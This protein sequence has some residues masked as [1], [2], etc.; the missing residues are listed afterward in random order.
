MEPGRWGAEA[1]EQGVAEEGDRE[2]VVVE[3]EWEALV[4]VLEGIVCAQPAGRLGP[5][6]S[7]FLVLKSSVRSAAPG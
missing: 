7:V 6:S 4:A 2:E 5:I 3:D 1:P